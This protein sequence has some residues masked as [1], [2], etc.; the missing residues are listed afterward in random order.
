MSVNGGVSLKA[1]W[2]SNAGLESRRLIEEQNFD[3]V[4]IQDQSLT[5]IRNPS[6]TLTFGKR[7]ADLIDKRD[8]KTVI[9]QT[10]SRKNNPRSQTQ[11]D[12]T[13]YLL[14][15]ATDA[16]LAPVAEAW[17]LARQE[18]PNLELYD[19]DGSHPSEMGSYLTALVF[20]LTLFDQDISTFKTVSSNRWSLI[21]MKQCEWLALQTISK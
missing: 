7:L 4:V 14:Q 12:S 3:W 17:H 19:E 1:H 10:W 8:G 20:Y 16:T 9:F 18:Y 2:E 15:R 11:L 21:E 6:S 5:P 13:F